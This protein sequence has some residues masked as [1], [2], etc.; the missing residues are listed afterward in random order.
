MVVDVQV[1]FFVVFF[2]AIKSTFSQNGN[3]QCINIHE[4]EE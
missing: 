4:S 1:C 3:D 2:K